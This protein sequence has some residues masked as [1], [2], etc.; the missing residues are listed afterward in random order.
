M[1][2]SSNTKLLAQFDQTSLTDVI[3]QLLIFFR[4]S[5]S[6]VVAP[7]DQG[8]GSPGSDGR[9]GDGARRNRHPERRGQLFPNADRIMMEDFGPPL[10]LLLSNGR[11]RIVVVRADR[12]AMLQ[13]TIRII[14]I[15]KAAGAS[16]L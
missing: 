13:S 10:N 2:F 9:N 11:D 14:D 6:L 12:N 16:R 7:G 15:V 5:S 1:R 8:A 4:L 3:L